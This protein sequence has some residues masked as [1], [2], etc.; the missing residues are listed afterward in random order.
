[1]VRR[2]ARWMVRLLSLDI[3]IA[4]C[5]DGSLVTRGIMDGY[6]SAL[7]WR[8]E[9]A[10]WGSSLFH[11]LTSSPNKARL[12]ALSRVEDG[13]SQEARQEV[14]RAGNLGAHRSRGATP[15][16]G[17]NPPPPAEVS[18][19]RDRADGVESVLPMRGKQEKSIITTKSF[20]QRARSWTR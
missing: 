17:S 9:W 18:A 20:S 15:T 7:W 11:C 3:G 4:S 10:Q 12:L 1:M 16:G 14:R 5:L 13:L 19:T 8:W 6:F 2:Y